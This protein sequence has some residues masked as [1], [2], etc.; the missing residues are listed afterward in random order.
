LAITLAQTLADLGGVSLNYFPVI[1]LLKS[2]ERVAGV[3]ARDLETGAEFE[4]RSR[5]VINATGAFVDQ[6]LALDERGRPP[7][8]AP[9][10]GIHIVLERD[11]LPGDCAFVV[12]HTD[13]GR[14]LFAIPWHGKTLV[15]TTDTP[16]PAASLEP[17]P[18]PE[19]LDFLLDHAGRYLAT[20]PSR[21]DV[22]ST[23]AGIRPLV[24]PRKARRTAAISREHYIETSPSGLV[25]IAGGKWTTYRRMGEEAVD[26]A[27]QAGLPPRESRTRALHLHGWRDSHD[28]GDPLAV[29]GADADEIRKLA[30]ARPELAAKLHPR[31]PYI[32]AEVVW[33]ARHEMA[34]TVEDVLSR[35]TRGLFLDARASVEAA[36]AVAALLA[37]ELG[38]DAEWARRQI[39]DFSVLARGYVPG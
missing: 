8:I 15:G 22:L 38:R 9:S 35:R 24:A 6:V 23:F 34:R 30:A 7:L 10:Q 1:G 16:V 26:T 29:Y 31:V 33:A 3:R 21:R 2:N 18:L 32:Q 36:E 28:A 14:V 37:A 20:R 11:F 4:V 12:P 13:D 19:E 27:I 17:R 39:T 25:T 5:A